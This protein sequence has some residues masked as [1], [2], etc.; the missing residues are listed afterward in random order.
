MS[1]SSFSASYS[2]LIQ[3]PI[4]SVGRT[5]KTSFYKE[6]TKDSIINYECENHLVSLI[7]EFHHLFHTIFIITW[8]DEKIN[9]SKFSGFKNCKI[10]KLQDLAPQLKIGNRNLPTDFN[11]KYKQFYALSKAIDFVETENVIKIRTDQYIDL[12]KLLEEHALAAEKDTS[13]KDKIFIP[14]VSNSNFLV[15]DFYFASTKKTFHSFVN[16]MIWNNYLEFNSSI[17]IDL[18]LKYAYVNFRHEIPIP[19]RT[20][21]VNSF[22]KNN[23]RDKVILTNFLSN[24]VYK[25]LSEE[26]YKTVIWRGDPIASIPSDLVFKHTDHTLLLDKNQ[27]RKSNFLDYAYINI[28]SYIAVRF[29]FLNGTAVQRWIT[30]LYRK[31]KRLP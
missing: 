19:I 16:A 24:T 7:N 28:P 3:G 15:S 5:G 14:F 27:F 31:I 8:S 4:L 21:F 30:K 23:N 25:L 10:I 13:N 18:S 9:E 11:N 26:V 1:N 2:L 12:K 29:P 17:H 22:S 6:I 20:Y